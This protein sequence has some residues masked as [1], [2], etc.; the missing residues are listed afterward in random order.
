M[1]RR[2]PLSSLRASR[3]LAK[4]GEVGGVG[5]EFGLQ[6][7]WKLGAALPP[8]QMQAREESER[9]GC[10]RGGAG[11]CRAVAEPVVGAPLSAA[12]SW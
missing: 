10:G 6:R 7:P 2:A 4:A 3:R 8:S 9:P 5:P 12:P 11:S 1:L